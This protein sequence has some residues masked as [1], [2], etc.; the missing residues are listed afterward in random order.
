MLPLR[1]RN[2]A[3]NTLLTMRSSRIFTRRRTERAQCSCAQRTRPHFGSVRKDALF[4]RQSEDRQ[5]AA[6][7]GVFG[8]AGIATDRAKASRSDLPLCILRN[9][10][11]INGIVPGCR[12]VGIEQAGCK[13]DSRPAADTRQ[14][15]NILL[16]IVLKGIDVA[17]DARRSLELVK[18]LAR[19]GIHRLEVALERA[20]E[21]DAARSCQ[22]AGP[23]RELFRV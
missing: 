21:H 11:L 14:H 9:I 6:E 16:A 8:Q 7:R 20:V 19:L 13:T 2:P 23:H 5:R 1:T 15:G 22:R 12:V 17:D 10:A 4:T 3:T 18:F